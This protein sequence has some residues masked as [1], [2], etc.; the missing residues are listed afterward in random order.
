MI[1]QP[2]PA[3]L[4]LVQDFVNTRRISADPAKNTDAL[5]SP[6]ALLAWCRERGRLTGAGEPTEAEWA[7]AIAVREGLRAVLAGHNDGTIAQDAEVLRRLA[8]VT[9]AIPLRVD[10][11]DGTPTLRPGADANTVRGLLGD[12]LAAAASGGNWLRLKACRD[13]LC[14]EIFYDTS[15]NRSGAWCSMRICGSRAKQRRFAQRHRPTPG[16]STSS[17]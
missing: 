17:G 14:R 13:P 12:V 16:E 15:K 2:A 8:A 11:T 4:D 1:G 5:S 7:D 3:P 9:S 10:F 6:A